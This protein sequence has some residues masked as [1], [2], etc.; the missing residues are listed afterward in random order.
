M[1]MQRKKNQS[2]RAYILNTWCLQCPHLTQCGH[3]FECEVVPNVTL[4]LQRSNLKALYNFLHM[5]RNA[6][7][8]L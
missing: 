5:C 4:S 8:D 7:Q 3:G 2:S 1:H 6:P